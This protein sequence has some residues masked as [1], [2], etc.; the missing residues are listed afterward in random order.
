MSFLD[1]VERTALM[2]VIGAIRGLTIKKPP[3]EGG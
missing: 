2:G 1:D 3:G